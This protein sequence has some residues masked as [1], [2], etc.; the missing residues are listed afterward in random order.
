MNTQPYTEYVLVTEARP[1][2]SQSRAQHNKKKL[3]VLLQKFMS[4]K[5][6]ESKHK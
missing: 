2:Q 1:L 4:H 3:V 5:F 6:N